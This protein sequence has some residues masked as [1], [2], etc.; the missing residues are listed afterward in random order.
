[1]TFRRRN[2]ISGQFAARTIEMLESPAYRVLSRS[3]HMVISRLEI[4][5]GHH[6]GNDNGRLAVTTEDFIKY[7]MHRTSAAPAIREAEALG[8][9]RV[10]ERGRGGNAE[11]RSP[12]RFLLTFAH[13]RDSQSSPPTNDWRRF[14]T[15]EEAAQVARA[16]RAN[17]NQ[18]AVELGKKCWRNRR[19]KQNTGT[20]ISAGSVRKQRTETS[21]P[22]VR[23]IRTTS[24]DEKSE[25]QSISRGGSRLA[26]DVAPATNCGEAELSLATTCEDESL[27]IAEEGPSSDSA[28]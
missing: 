5:L 9:I 14:K 7:G 22:P 24:S 12:N 19:K 18:N 25:L 13:G 6:G 27:R 3:A 2:R 26:S 15:I 28:V 10:T 8:F 16:A 20:E 17:K 11:F 4:E 21:T 1:M 23:K